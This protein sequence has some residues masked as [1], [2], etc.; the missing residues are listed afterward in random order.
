VQQCKLKTSELQ[1]LVD[2]Q[3]LYIGSLKHQLAD[4]EVGRI[5]ASDELF[6]TRSEVEVLKKSH[7]QSTAE[8]DVL[9]SQLNQARSEAASLAEKLSVCKVE[10]ESNLE[11]LK[12]TSACENAA[13]RKELEVSTQNQAL[14]EKLLRADA[15]IR[16]MEVQ[17]ESQTAFAA[18]SAKVSSAMRDACSN[19]EILM[20]QMKKNMVSCASSE[21]AARRRISELEAQVSDY[22]V[23]IYNKPQT[24]T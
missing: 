11:S 21:A 10:A 15:R 3:V 4:S 2:A 23:Y 7:S 12:Y 19:S 17:V 16:E 1:L 20:A 9:K 8:I 22:E 14:L 13:R 18:A 5:S 24:S 6:S